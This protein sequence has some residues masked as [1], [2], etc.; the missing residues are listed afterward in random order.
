MLGHQTTASERA[1]FL[2][3]MTKAVR[4]TMQ[5]SIL[6]V[7]VILY[8]EGVATGGIMIAASVLVGRATQP[9]EVL[10]SS[11]RTFVAAKEA[12]FRL[13][14]LLEAIPARESGMALPAPRGQVGLEAIFVAP[15]GTKTPILKGVSL[16]IEPGEIVGVIGPSASGKSTL[17][18]AMVGVWPP[19]SG[20]VRLDGADLYQWNKDDLGPYMGYLPQDIELFSGNIAENIARFSEVNSEKVIEA[21]K[22]AG[23]HDMILRLPNGYDTQIGES[24]AVLSG[25]QRQRIGI[26]RA[27]YG[28]PS[29]I[30]LDEPNSNLDEIGEAA[31]LATIRQLKTLGRTV[32]LITH[33]VNVLQSVD[34][35]LL[36]LDGQVQAFGPRD[37]VLQAL[38]QAKQQVAGAKQ[39]QVGNQNPPSVA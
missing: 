12:Y 21:A 2:S 22:L 11:W 5:S 6:A 29:L 17:A 35:L 24:G 23:V 37:Q 27:I 13:N 1:A 18:R 4:M 20:K 31:L 10:I 15:P 26:A 9:I 32:V 16:K 30:I 38:N 34:K 36:M 33:R 39:A 7:G 19:Y 28:N 25:G 8:I 3:G 14:Q